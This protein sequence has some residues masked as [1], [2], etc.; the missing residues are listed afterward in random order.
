VPMGPLRFHSLDPVD[1]FHRFY[2]ES[3]VWMDTHWLG[4]PAQKCPLDLWIYQEILFELRPDLVIETGTAAGGSAFFFAS[5]MDLLGHGKVMTI[6]IADLA[7]R[8]EHN[9]IT[10]VSGSSVDENVLMLARASAAEADTVMVVLDSAH[11]AAHVLAELRSY[12]D[13][14]SPGSYL[15]VE[16]TNVNGHPVLPSHGAGPRE[17]V[18]LFLSQRD[19]FVV[20]HGREKF[21]MT[22]NPGGYLRRSD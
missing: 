22:F 10:Y 21:L 1:P 7:G 18:Q 19:N 9:R 8:P 16:D 5:M 2:Y 20:D 4:V 13:L 11:D 15:I 14:V 6:D 17:A 12:C 3:R